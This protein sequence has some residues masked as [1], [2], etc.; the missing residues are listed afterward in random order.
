MTVKIELCL[1]LFIALINYLM[2]KGNI[3]SYNHYKLEDYKSGD[4]IIVVDPDFAEYKL[5]PLMVLWVCDKYVHCNYVDGVKDS[6]TPFA[7][8]VNQ[9]KKI[10]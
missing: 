7:F 2:N 5:P 4:T 8:N 9:I 6:V 10:K 1:M 3:N